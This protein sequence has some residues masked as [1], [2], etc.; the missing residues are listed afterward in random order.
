MDVAIIS[1]IAQTKKSV[2]HQDTNVIM[3]MIVVINKMKLRAAKGMWLCWG[4]EQAKL[5]ASGIPQKGLQ[6]ACA[7]TIYFKDVYAN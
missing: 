7:L 3:I 2:S 5:L 4:Y 6:I 1:S